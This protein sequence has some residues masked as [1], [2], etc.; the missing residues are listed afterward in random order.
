MEA[1]AGELR[2]WLDPSLLCASG[3]V[4]LNL[5]LFWYVLVTG[6]GVFPWSGCLLFMILFSLELAAI[7][8][9]HRHLKRL[10]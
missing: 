3:V 5:S 2:L 9:I 4:A 8:R 10:R 7:L 6:F 1:I